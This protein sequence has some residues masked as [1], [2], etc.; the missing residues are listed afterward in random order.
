MTNSEYIFKSRCFHI[1]FYDQLM[2]I[3]TTKTLT[4]IEEVLHFWT[5]ENVTTVLY[6]SQKIQTAH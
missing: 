3:K 4:Y 2:S 6:L 5:Q 1:K